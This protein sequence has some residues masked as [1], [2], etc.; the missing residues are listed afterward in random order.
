MKTP[1]M[2]DHAFFSKD[3][4]LSELVRVVLHAGALVQQYWPGAPSH[5]VSTGEREIQQKGDGTP[6]SKADYL[7]NAAL[8]EGIQRLFPGDAI[9]S[10]ES[11]YDVDELR[12]AVRTWVIDPL[13]GTSAFL[14]GRDDFSIL[15]ALCE[16]THP[17]VGIQYFP[18]RDEL[19]LAQ[20]G[21][22]AWLNGAP[23]QVSSL[24]RCRESAVYIRN[25]DLSR[26]ELASPWM[27]SGM[28]FAKVARG[29]L[30]GAILRIV[31][32]REW[33]IAAPISIIQEAGGRVSD[34]DGGPVPCGIG[35]LQ[36]RYVI[37]SNG[38]VHDEL[39]MLIP[40]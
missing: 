29:E 37:A 32:H 24:E 23:L 15:V 27:D 25:F 21:R 1:S 17:S 31:T 2:H 26:P 12:R 7:S 30:D 14:E 39:L 10:E 13:D 9:L 4:N 3:P 5:G 18:A 20:Q 38:R 19:L 16:R 11:A 8:T 33:D 22:G 34:E 6:V 28:A 35:S 36:C 40:R